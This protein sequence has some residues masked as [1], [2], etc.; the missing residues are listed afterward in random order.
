MAEI[1]QDNQVSID[2]TTKEDN[3]VK[4]R[5]MYERQLEAERQSKL[6]LEQ[7]LA[8]LERRSSPSETFDDDENDEPYID[9]K[10]LKKESVKIKTEA[11]KE[12]KQ[13]VQEAVAAALAEERQKNWLKQNP[14]F[15]EVM[16]NAQK[17]QDLDPEAAEAFLE[18]PPGFERQKLV[19]KTIKLAGL[20]KK[21]EPQ[22]SIQEKIDSNKRSPYYQPS[23][24]GTSPYANQGDFSP[25]GQKNAYEKLQQ[26]KKN[27]RLG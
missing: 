5:Q 17:I 24:V 26:L 19:Y 15:E 1:E 20:H 25:V 6:Q 18:L 4:Q 11:V 7:R 27:L 16:K 14:D 12:S 3:L 13:Y 23:G 9:R 8:E 10:R 2:K 22:Q 21:Q